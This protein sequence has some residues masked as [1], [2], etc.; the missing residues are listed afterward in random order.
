MCIIFGTFAMTN[1]SHLQVVFYKKL[2]GNEPVREWLYKL[3]INEKK[4]IGED[5]K[6][7]QFGWPMGMPL[8]RKIDTDLWELRSHLDNKI[9]RV[10]FTVIKD[11][12]ILLHGFIKKTPKTPKEDITLAKKRLSKVRSKK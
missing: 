3:S 4:I 11:T 2:S 1:L 10:F 12:M 6:T 5:I 7:V 9:A 8:I